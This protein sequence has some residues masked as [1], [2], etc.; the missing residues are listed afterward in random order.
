MAKSFRLWGKKR[1][2]RMSGWWLMGLVSEAAF[3]GVL[4][5]LGIVSL[6]T[7]A[8]WQ[9]FWPESNFLRVGFG[10]WLMI[11]ASSS[12]IIIGLTGFILKV[13]R[14]LASPEK[15]SVLV[16]QAKRDH[17]RRSRDQRD[18]HEGRLPNLDLLTDSPGTKLAYR[19]P[20]QSGSR[21]QIILSTCFALAWNTLVAIL[22]VIAVQKWLSG[23]PVWFLNALLL[24]FLAVS[25]I[26]TRWFFRL[27]RVNAGIGPTAVEISGLP[28]LP[29]KSYQVYLCQYGR[30]EFDNLK[31]RLV[32]YEEATYEQG[33]DI[34]TE[35]TQF[36]SYEA[37]SIRC[38]HGSDR[39]QRSP[40]QT[41]LPDQAGSVGQSGK[42]PDAG[43]EPSTLRAEPENPLEL[44]CQIQL[45]R[46]MMHSFC[47]LHN[48]VRWKIVVE[49]ENP[50][51]P[52]FRRS[53][54]VVVY[55]LDAQ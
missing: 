19:L 45:P 47:G 32:G 20:E 13:S 1:G 27:Y 22:L 6:T 23:D 16:N 3:F 37:D 14:T 8:T 40:K 44:T 33:T 25:F 17:Q 10:F 46:D 26:A 11:I 29:G 43:R 12:L 28:L 2:S 9:M 30:T 53:F 54:P 51:W 35:Q 34:R 50:T 41:E 39:K 55:P 24:P 48:S 7:V 38:F 49:G 36:A 21:S 42:L 5:I 31:I 15:R 4:L 18:S 52:T